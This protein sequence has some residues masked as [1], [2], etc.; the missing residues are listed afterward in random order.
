MTDPTDLTGRCTCGA[1]TYRLTRPPMF[2]HACHCSWCQ[3]ETG[4]AFAVNALIE[5]SAVQVTGALTA[6]TL[7]TASGKGQVVMRC[8]TCQV[9]IYSH[10]AGSGDRMAFVRT[11]TLDDPAACPPDIHIFAASKRPWVV[12]G[13]GKPVMEGYY[14]AREVWPTAAQARFKALKG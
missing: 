12:L 9:A 8:P 13:D 14:N 2:V 5:T 4:S 7:P 6:L 1:V 3:R 10:Y 11:G